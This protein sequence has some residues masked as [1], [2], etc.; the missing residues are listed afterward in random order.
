V[1]CGVEFAKTG[2]QPW[3]AANDGFVAADDARRCG[4]IGGYQLRGPVSGAY[5]LG[6]GERNVIL[7]NRC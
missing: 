6:Q 7:D 3:R 5:V 2:V 4:R 1:H